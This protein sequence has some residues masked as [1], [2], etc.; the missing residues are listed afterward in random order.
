M[1]HKITLTG[2]ATS[3]LR[4]NYKY[5]TFDMIESGSKGAPKGLPKSTKIHYTVFVN[6]K[7]LNKA[8]VT[9]DN[10]CKEKLMIQGEPTLD[11]PMDQCPGEVAVTCFQ[12]QTIQPKEKK[13][14]TKKSVQ[15]AI[16]EGSKL[17]D[18]NSIVIP[19]AF[20]NSSPNPEKLKEKKDTLTKEKQF[21]KPILIDPKTDQLIDGY[22]WYLVAKELNYKEVPVC[23]G[24]LSPV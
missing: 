5:F 16:P 15:E 20:L 11:V 21:K 10:I 4:K 12:I 18:I 1:P 24:E 8:G 22:T 19:E 9:K 17:V 14:E 2:K 7:Q 3:G 23:F 6:Q 13:E